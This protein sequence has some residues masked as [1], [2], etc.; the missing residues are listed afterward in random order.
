MV[1]KTHITLLRIILLL[2]VVIQSNMTTVM[3]LSPNAG[4]LFM[5]VSPNSSQKDMIEA[6]RIVRE[7]M[8]ELNID[9]PAEDDPKASAT[10][11]ACQM[12]DHLILKTIDQTAS[13]IFAAPEP[14]F[15]AYD[16]H[17]TQRKTGPPLGLRAPPYFLF[18]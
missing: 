14:Q 11:E 3:A 9:I 5:C 1:L 7:L 12:Q 16:I 17:I 10:C 8:Q 18:S 2:A 13:Q 4:A 15:S 6:Q